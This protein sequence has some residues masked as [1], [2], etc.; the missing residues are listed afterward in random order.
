MNEKNDKKFQFLRK[1][2]FIVGL[3]LLVEGFV[4]L[5]KS[6][7]FSLP[8]TSSYL[9]FD[10]IAKQLDPVLKTVVDLKI[11]PLVATFLILSALAL[12]AV[13]LPVI[14]KWYVKNLKRGVN[15]ARWIEYSVTSSLMIV[16]ISMLVGIYDITSLLVIF[17]LNAMMILF[18]WE[19]ESHNQ[20]TT[21]TNWTSFIFG[22]IA[23]I[24]PWVAITIYLLGSGGDGGQVP[25]FVYWIYGSLFLFFNIFAINMILQYKKVG[26]WKDYIYGEKVYIILSLV[27]KSL[28]A[29]QVFFGTLR[30][31]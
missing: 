14:N 21:K 28:L 27:A 3:I 24:I 22:S 8:V 29:W 17:F 30:P 1:F 26:P 7:N 13:A 15:Y 9:R 19:M 2:N 20:V 31:M 5:W 4:M 25:S 11:G 6:T 12:F 23:G 18:G 10:P 16:V